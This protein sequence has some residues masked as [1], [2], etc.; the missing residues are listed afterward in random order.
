MNSRAKYVEEIVKIVNVI[1]GHPAPGFR[2]FLFPAVQ[3]SLDKTEQKND[4]YSSKLTQEGKR[5]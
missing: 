4:T 2:Q 1:L 3:D 5:C